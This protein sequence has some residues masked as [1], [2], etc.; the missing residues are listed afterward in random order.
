MN[1]DCEL[2]IDELGC[3]SGGDGVI[4]SIIKAV[5]EIGSAIGDAIMAGLN[6]LS[7]G[8]GA[9][10]GSGVDNVIRNLPGL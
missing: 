6:P 9:G 8:G 10:S 1:N 7:G 4:V 2:N 3:V 5:H